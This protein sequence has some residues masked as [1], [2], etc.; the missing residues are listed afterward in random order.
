MAKG[1]KTIIPAS[2]G[3]KITMRLVP[4]QAPAE[5]VRIVKTHLKQICP[6]FVQM[7]I[8]EVYATEAVLFDI[9]TPLIQAA[10]KALKEGFGNEAVYIRCGGSIPVVSTFWRE[11]GKP[12]A[13]MG[14]GLTNNGAHSPNECFSIET[15][16]LATHASSQLLRSF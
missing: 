13:L 16:H 15:F 3:A 4:D 7:T 1:S 9:D 11:L 10:C 8:H 5:I 2:A 6:D 12:V 14:F